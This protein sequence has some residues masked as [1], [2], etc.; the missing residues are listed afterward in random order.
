MTP[1]REPFPP[2][3]RPCRSWHFG[4]SSMIGLRRVP[5][6]P[7]DARGM[8]PRPLGAGGLCLR[9]IATLTVPFLILSIALGAA[10]AGSPPCLAG[11]FSL[12]RARNLRRADGYDRV[13]ALR[14]RALLGH[15]RRIRVSGLPARLLQRLGRPV[16]LSDL[17]RRNCRGRGR[18]QRVP[19]VR[20]RATTAKFSARPPVPSAAG[21]AR[22]ARRHHGDR[23]GLLALARRRSGRA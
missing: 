3:R 4:H 6:E 22:G 11:S 16:V 1:Q 19:S 21:A 9:L 13:H 12:L 14:A 18:K 2:T 7:A 15:L 20:R 5:L 8:L 17:Q 23:A 10:R